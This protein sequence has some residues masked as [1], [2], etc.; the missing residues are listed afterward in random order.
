LVSQQVSEIDRGILT[1]VNTQLTMALGNADERREAV[2]VASTD[3]GG[4][5]NELQVLSRGQLVMSS[6]LRDIALPIQ[7][8]SYDEHRGLNG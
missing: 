7:V 6:S 3:I 4:F 8:A 5:A 2:R 1:Q